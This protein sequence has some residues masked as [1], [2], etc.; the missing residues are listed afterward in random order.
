[1]HVVH[2]LFNASGVHI[3][4]DM[5]V[6]D[7]ARM[8]D[9][10]KTRRTQILF[11]DAEIEAIDRWRVEH[12]VWSFGEAVRRLVQTGLTWEAEQQKQ[13]DPPGEGGSP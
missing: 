7:T 9:T 4:C 1:M 3:A 11:S 6:R 10:A 12:R 8:P 2:H 5:R 13:N